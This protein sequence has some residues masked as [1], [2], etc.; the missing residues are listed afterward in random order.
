MDGG[1]QVVGM[2]ASHQQLGRDQVLWPTAL[3]DAILEVVPAAPV[4][5]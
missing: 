5:P 1:V 2:K 4:K 3:W